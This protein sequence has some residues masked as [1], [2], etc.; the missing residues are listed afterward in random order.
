[1][2]AAISDPS[3]RQDAIVDVVRQWRK[4]DPKAAE[5]WLNQQSPDPATRQR[6]EP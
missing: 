4:T 3:L 5:A 1:M 6:L 2:A